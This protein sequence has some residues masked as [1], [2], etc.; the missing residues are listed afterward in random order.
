[1]PIQPLS[2]HAWLRFDAVERLLPRD[3]R[4]VLEIGAGQGSVGVMLAR[5]YD[6]LGLEPDRTSFETARRRIGAGRL[7]NLPLE[8]AEDG[9]YDLVVALEVL[10]HIEDDLGALRRWIDRV[11][12]GGYLLVSVPARPDHF[13]PTDVKAGH[14][15]RYDREGLRALLAAAELEEIRIDT[16]GF[17]L[18]YALEVARNQVVKRLAS[19]ADSLEARTAASGRWLQPSERIAPLMFAA[20]YPFRLLQRPFSRTRLG[21]GLVARGRR[22]A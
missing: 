5:R 9:R 4:T 12:P 17:P 15:R 21:T 2:L 20:A 16:Y 19:P 6:Y 18:G 1:V 10:E 3:A 8:E 13:G 22:A 11:D 14:Y 7:L